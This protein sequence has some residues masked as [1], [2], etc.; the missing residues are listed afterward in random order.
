MLKSE[1]FQDSYC[2]FIS[3]AAAG[4][5]A[6]R[7]LEFKDSAIKVLKGTFESAPAVIVIPNDRAIKKIETELFNWSKDDNILQG[8]GFW[9]QFGMGY[10]DKEWEVVI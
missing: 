7:V 2:I 5:F 10:K 8:G 1:L 4:S 6:K 3:K 9:G